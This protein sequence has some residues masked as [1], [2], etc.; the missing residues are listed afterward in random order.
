M[1]KRTPK[2]QARFEAAT[3]RAQQVAQDRHRR[4][5]ATRIAKL[6]QQIIDNFVGDVAT[7]VGA[8]A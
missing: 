8:K 1:S 3:R 2:Q 4:I 7:Y 6:E 5:E